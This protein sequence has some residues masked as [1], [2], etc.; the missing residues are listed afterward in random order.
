[1]RPTA[2]LCLA[3]LAALLAPPPL[4]ADDTA[5]LAEQFVAD[6]QERSLHEH[7]TWRRLLHFRQNGERSEIKTESF[8][9]D[10]QGSKDPQAELAAT[11]RAYFATDSTDLDQSPRCR[12]PARYYWLSQHLPL[13]GYDPTLDEC[14]RFKRWALLE[15]VDSVS[16]YLVSGYF[17]NPASTFGHSLLK[18]NSS[19][20][21]AAT[22]LFDLTINFGAL[23]PEG[24]II[25]TYILRGLTGGYDA[26]F[27]DQYFYTQDRVYTRTEFRD[28]WDYQLNLTDRQRTLLV[29]HI[30]EII[31]K[32]FT[33]YFLK[34][35][36]AYRIAD[37][38]DLVVEEELLTRANAWYVPVELFHRLTAIDQ[39]RREQG[40]A[41]LIAS[42]DTIP[43]SQRA[44]YHTFAE[45]E[46]HSRAIAFELV[47]S[48]TIPDFQSL[49]SLA[50]EQRSAILDALLAYHQYKKA[51]EEPA[52]SPQRLESIR[53]ILLQRLQLPV[54]TKS[55]SNS[56]QLP[57][58]PTKGS[59]SMLLGAG[60]A[61]N[62]RDHTYLLT[63]FTAFSQE[64]LAPTPLEGSELVA[65]NATIAHYHSKTFLDAL[66][67]IRVTKIN[68]PPLHLPGESRRSWQLRIAADRVDR[69]PD[70]VLDWNASLGAGRAW[71]LSENTTARAL[72]HA[73][74]HSA[75]DLLRIK[76]QLAIASEWKNL[77][78]DIQV[79]SEW[80]ET[81]SANFLWKAAAQYQLKPNAALR[82]ELGN[83]YST[84]RALS[85][86]VYW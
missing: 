5:A 29:L 22:G 64:S 85:F 31:G 56:P 48:D 45:L 9:L 68:T 16:L 10:P 37:L 34:Q 40:R 27:S 12:F 83:E 1:M 77:R 36:C 26:G 30:W 78:A 38:V 50:P 28:I 70:T 54:S 86:L 75:H 3:L 35:N 25:P 61:Q 13:P 19:Q 2:I 17:G 49:R 7:P 55:I 67:L 84:R 44:L 72:L 63:R 79:G 59:R 80:T 20:S 71:K 65:I 69:Q 11:I 33:Y 43:S 57:L 4:S 32:K 46:P 82:L 66:E 24:E 62:E 39:Q 6:A 41:P 21:T 60:I 52:P 74:L 23:V 47:E 76:P 18:L 15:K 51:S 8:F 14:P 53:Q 73:S 42:I 81:E 58:T